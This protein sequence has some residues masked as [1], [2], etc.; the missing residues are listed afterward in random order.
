MLV[1]SIY[2]VMTILYS[3]SLKTKIIVDVVTLSFL[4]TLRIFTGSVATGIE[5]TPWLF[6]FFHFLSNARHMPRGYKNL[7]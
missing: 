5:T 3:I 7:P 1:L 2:A 4:F 6:A